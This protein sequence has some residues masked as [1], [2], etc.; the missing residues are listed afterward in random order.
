MTDSGEVYTWGFNR[1]SQLG[2]VIESSTQ[3]IKSEAEQIQS[4]PKRILGPLKK[5]VIK[6]IAA[7]KCASCAWNQQGELYTW[8]T[9]HGQLG[10]V[11]HSAFP[12]R[13]LI[14]S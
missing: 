10:E 11:L 14:F 13:R 6:G 7:S 8:G 5:E 4:T 12:W 3:P 2:Y 1:F 9:N